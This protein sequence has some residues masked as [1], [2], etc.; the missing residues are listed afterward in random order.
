MHPLSYSL[1]PLDDLNFP[2]IGSLGSCFFADDGP[3]IHEYFADDR[4]K[5]HEYFADDRPKMNESSEI[6]VSEGRPSLIAMFLKTA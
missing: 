2:R 4:P 6:F 3:K 1:T 5:I